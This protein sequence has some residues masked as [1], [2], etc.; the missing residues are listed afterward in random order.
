MNQ[1][2]TQP[3]F[4]SSN[5]IQE[6]TLPSV[7]HLDQKYLTLPININGKQHIVFV[8]EQAIYIDS[9]TTIEFTDS[10]TNKTPDIVVMQSNTVQLTHNNGWKFGVPNDFWATISY[11][12]NRIECVIKD[13][14][15][16]LIVESESSDLIEF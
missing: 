9:E 14:F 2:T 12:N 16:K 8:S 11:N 15:N 5:L 13:R 10:I 3:P 6:L 7:A 1:T 4:L